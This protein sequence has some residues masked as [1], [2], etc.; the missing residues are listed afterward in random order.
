MQT[1]IFSFVSYGSRR[2]A[3][4]WDVSFL[5]ASS[6]ENALSNIKSSG[7]EEPCYSDIISITINY[8]FYDDVRDRLFGCT[9]PCC[10]TKTCAF[11]RVFRRPSAS[12][13]HQHTIHLHFN[14]TA[15]KFIPIHLLLGEPSR[16]S[17]RDFIVF[18]HSIINQTLCFKTYMH[19]V[20]F[21]YHF[22]VNVDNWKHQTKIL[23]LC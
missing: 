5:L 9:A 12:S 22:C 3:I 7:M 21:H 6:Q 16:Y 11:L 23:L 19:F 17:I 13:Q 20:L 14:I 1:P 10:C 18:K 8:C 4:N 15:G 2:G